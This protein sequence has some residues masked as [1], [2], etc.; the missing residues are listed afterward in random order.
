VSPNPWDRYAAIEPF[1][2]VLADPK[3]LRKNLTAEA[4]GEFFATGDA[5]VRHI[6]AV[7][8]QKLAPIFS[9]RAALEFGCGPGRVAVALADHVPAVVA[10]DVSPAMLR[11]AEENA[12]RRG[13][14]QIAFQTPDELFAS[15]HR[16]DLI[17]ASLVFQHIPPQDGLMLL[18][19]LLE[20]LAPLGVGVF[21]FPFRRSANALANAARAARR[22][23]GVANA[24]A[25]LLLRKPR[26][27]PFLHPYVYDLGAV[28]STFHSAGFAD[29]YITIET[30][31]ELDV[32]T[33]FVRRALQASDVEAAQ[34]AA[35]PARGAGFIDVREL[36]RSASMEELHSKAE[37]YFSSLRDWDHHL[38]KPF[39]NA[40]DTPAILSN[41]AVVIEA[42]RLHPGV[43]VLEFGGGTG[44]LSRFL[45]QLGCRVIL[46]DV[47]PTALDIARELYRRLPPIGNTPEPE[48][49]AFD[50][51]RIDLPDASVDRIITFDAFHHVTNPGEVLAEMAR[52]LRP[53]GIAAFAEPGPHHSKTPQS[54]FEMRTYGVIE[55]DVDIRSIWSTAREL[56]FTEL[57]L[58]AF[59]RHPMFVTLDE[60]DDLLLGGDTYVRFAEEARAQLADVRD[61]VLYKEGAA[62][63]DSR[64]AE[65]LQAQIEVQVR[66]G[67]VRA[68]VTNTGTAEWLAARERYG[69]VALGCHAFDEQGTLVEFDLHWEGLPSNVPPG[70][71][72]DLTFT[73]PP[74]P[75]GTHQLEFD[76][77]ASEVTWF[78]QVGST[79][80]RVR[81]PAA[82]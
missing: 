43:T 65:G 26:D 19:R 82:P 67:E 5:Y 33:V 6:L 59:T 8:R 28:I 15:A 37:E 16:F 53:G 39:A 55:N 63:A 42:L 22:R 52:V 44:W 62:P 2:S 21:S 75:P 23:F 31:G 48:F 35:S 60:Y 61:F 54:Q 30:Q 29:P 76:M 7:V 14:A 41:V 79:P 51:R 72:V 58:A 56:G 49:R 73:L 1:F 50:G 10:V 17:N 24:A 78:A 57:K 68:T 66:G 36:M 64:R 13:V 3:F 27:F 46:T 45:T 81:V 25:N 11:A 80:A 70:A 18:R 12:R 77:V 20:R 71:S 4:E 38:A 9:P 69:G 47:S 40:A 34:P 74:L 32:A